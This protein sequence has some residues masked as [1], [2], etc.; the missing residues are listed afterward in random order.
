MASS[1]SW[2]TEQRIPNVLLVASSHVVVRIQEGCL[3]R[4]FFPFGEL[5]MESSILLLVASILVERTDRIEY[6]N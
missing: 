6:R 5:R 4:Q 2:E 1:S 3:K